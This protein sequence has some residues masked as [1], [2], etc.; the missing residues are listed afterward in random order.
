M[1]HPSL[2]LL[3]II[4]ILFVLMVACSFG[5][6]PANQPQPTAEPPSNPTTQ[7]PSNPTTEP[8]STPDI[9]FPLTG[10][11]QNIQKLSEEQ[12]NYQTGMSLQEVVDF[13]RLTL[14]A[15]GLVEREILTVIDAKAFSIVFDGSPNGKALVIQG[16]DLGNGT[17]NVN[18]RYEDT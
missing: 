14:T 6:S 8:A 2:Y 17:C 9:P 11:A 7:P 13:Y 16:V 10:D 1:K 12:V 3:F 4:G 18:I 5:G 15:Q